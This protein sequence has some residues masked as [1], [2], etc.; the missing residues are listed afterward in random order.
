VW[1][2]RAA[3]MGVLLRTRQMGDVEAAFDVC[4]PLMRE[5]APAVREAVVALLTEARRSD[6]AAA[7]EFLGRWKGKGDPRIL[8]A[9]SS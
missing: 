5:R 7:L 6:P 4:E 9:L 8:E 1:E 3:T 2:R